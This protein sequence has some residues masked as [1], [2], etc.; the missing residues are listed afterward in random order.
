MSYAGQSYKFYYIIL[1]Y[2]LFK[3]E[4]QNN[5]YQVNYLLYYVVG[6]E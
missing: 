6:M 2:W 1:I 5:K 3:F 4:A